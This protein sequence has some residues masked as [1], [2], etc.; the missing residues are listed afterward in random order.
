MRLRGRVRAANAR[1]AARRRTAPHTGRGAASRPPGRGQ[2]HGTARLAG[3][4]PAAVDLGGGTGEGVA[5]L[6]VGVLDARKVET[7]EIYR[8]PGVSAK[9]R[10]CLAAVLSGDRGG[11]ALSV[12]W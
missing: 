3:G 4:R 11:P 12:S 6:L 9:R 8:A 5:A 2:E 10:L 7:Q 1:P